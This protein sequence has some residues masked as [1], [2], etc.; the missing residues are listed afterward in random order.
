MVEFDELALPQDLDG[1][2]RLRWGRP[3]DEDA[4]AAFNVRLHSDEPDAPEEWLGNWT[5]DLLRGEHPM[6]SATDFTVV[7]E[8]ASGAIVSSQVL[9]SQVWSYDGIPFKV[10][11]PELVATDERYRRRGLIRRQMDI[12]HALSAQRGEMVQAITGIPWYYRMFGY[13]MALNL[14]GGREFFWT[15]Q[16]NDKRREDETYQI[17]PATEADIPA[18]NE[19]YDTHCAHSLIRHERSEAIWRY[20]LSGA[21]RKSPGALHAYMILD[22][23]GRHVAYCTFFDH[24]GAFYLNELGVTPGHSWRAVALFMM[25]ELKRR[26]DEL[27]KNREK[28]VTQVRMPWSDEHPVLKALGPQVEK[29]RNP[30]AWY[31]RVPDLTAFLQH[32]APALEERLSTSVV[33]GHTGRLRLNFFRDALSLRFKEGRLSEIGRYKP[34]TVED[35]D[36]LFPELTFLQLLF[37]YR[38]LQELDAA[39][40]DCYAENPEAA[41]VLEALFPKRPS[42]VSPLN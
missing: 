34:R 23:T 37:G 3:E 10:G 5:R 40:A 17:R 39:F 33:A 2:L 14:G 16:G 11:R 7:E 24:G 18:L 12:A 31:L 4:L 25:R 32:I 27:N 6:A 30:Y 26:A 42:W 22:E 35:A 1:G 9:I 28:V 29:R 20:Q 36:A 41:V 21:H 19:L 15:R 8:V 38:S 13:E